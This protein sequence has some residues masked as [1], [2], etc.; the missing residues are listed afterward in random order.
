MA[1]TEH[2]WEIVVIHTTLNSKVRELKGM[3]GKK[4]THVRQINKKIT[5]EREILKSIIL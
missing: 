1:S 4:T 3:E 5:E 2:I